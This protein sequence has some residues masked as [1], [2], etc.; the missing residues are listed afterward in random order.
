MD[1]IQP[2]WKKKSGS[3]DPASGKI[4]FNKGQKS[5]KVYILHFEKKTKII[6]HTNTKVNSLAGLAEKGIFW[7]F[8]A[9]FCTWWQEI[10]VV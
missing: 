9:G 3:I 7:Q 1:K 8:V 6:S 2:G 10:V 4:K 5:G